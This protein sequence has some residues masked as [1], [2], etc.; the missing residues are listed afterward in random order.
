MPVQ[1]REEAG[2]AIGRKLRAAI[3]WGVA[4]VLFVAVAPLAILLL[5]L[6]GMVSALA[7][8]LL[9]P[10][11]VLSEWLFDTSIDIHLDRIR[12]RT[13]RAVEACRRLIQRGNSDK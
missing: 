7:M 13:G 11:D 5:L 3:A 8:G 9:L 10:L 6:V 4:V 1:D 2:S 12:R